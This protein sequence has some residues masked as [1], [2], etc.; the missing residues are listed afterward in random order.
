MFVVVIGI[1]ILITIYL[2]FTQKQEEA[3]SESSSGLELFIDKTG[4]I[5]PELWVKSRDLHVN[6]ERS[7]RPYDKFYQTGRV[8]THDPIKADDLG[9]IWEFPL[10]PDD[11]QGNKIT[12]LG[13]AFCP[14]MKGHKK[15]NWEIT[16]DEYD[17]KCHELKNRQYQ[18]NEQLKNYLRADEN[19]K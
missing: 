10:Q 11:L 13:G 6:E 8:P 5:S 16:T 18:I 2:G 14:T 1:S 15:G 7:R 12:D 3:D 19:S 4:S 17:R 9:L